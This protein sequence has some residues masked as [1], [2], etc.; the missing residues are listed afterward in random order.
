MKANAEATFAHL[1]NL[2]QFAMG[3]KPQLYCSPE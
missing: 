1:I 2:T 3:F